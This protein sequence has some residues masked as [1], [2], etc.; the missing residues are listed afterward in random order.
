MPSSA[1]VLIATPREIINAGLKFVLKGRVSIVGEASSAKK[2][3]Q[4]IKKCAPAV[5]L[6][7]DRFPGP[8]PLGLAL[9]ILAET[10]AR[11]VMIGAEESPIYMARAC[12]AGISDYVLEGSS[13]KAIV[14]AVLAA[15]SGLS[16]K[17]DEAF[18]RLKTTLADK[19]ATPGI[20]LTPREQQVLRHVAHGLSNNEIA[21]ALEISVE[22]V[23]EHVQNV[24]RK[25]S[26][27]DR[28]H[29]AVWA[30]KSGHV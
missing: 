2:A 1:T 7:S 30:I 20:D 9:A 17:A 22:T 28:T 4:Q 12:A 13:S 11:V 3:L 26:M 24:L 21:K 27:R 18:R 29:A 8:D 19:T 25:T 16:S 15:A 23:K 5:A 10:K 14:N 6:V